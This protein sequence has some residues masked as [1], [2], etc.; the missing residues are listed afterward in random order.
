MSGHDAPAAPKPVRLLRKRKPAHLPVT[1]RSIALFRLGEQCNNDC[2]MCSNTGSMEAFFQ[3]MKEVMRR[4]GYLQSQGVRQ[5]VLTGGEPTIHP[6]FWGVVAALNQHGIR[7][8]INTHGRSFSDTDFADQAVFEGLGRAIVSFHSHIEDASM[9]ISGTN[10]RGHYE[11]IEGI[12]NLLERDVWLMLNY[13][14]TRQ[15]QGTLLEYLGYCA[16]NF[17]TKYQV[18]V[19]FPSTAGKGGQWDGIQFRFHEVQ[20]EIVEAQARAEELG[21]TLVFEGFPNC[22]LGDA[23][24]KNISR[25]GF[26]ET[27]YLD[28]VSGNDL[29]PI[30]F[31]EAEFSAYPESCV[32][33]AAIKQ[34]P[35]IARSYLNTYGAGEF[36][37]FPS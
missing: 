27:H 13:V 33:C 1:A 4:V 19:V 18:K 22:I 35:G 28:D 6:D 31:I 23:K 8:D 29:Y 3:P 25:S 14:M 15:N 12:K 36:V 16:T 24:H 9:V 37:P 11:T 17:G 7:W 26:G 20:S 10:S 21:I 32:D 5:V 34:C 2:P 30:Q